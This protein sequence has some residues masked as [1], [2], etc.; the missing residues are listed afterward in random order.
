M[1]QDIRRIDRWTD[2]LKDGLRL[3]TDI[4][5]SMNEKMSKYKYPVGKKKKKH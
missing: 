3:Q 2:R 4:L 5:T 1:V